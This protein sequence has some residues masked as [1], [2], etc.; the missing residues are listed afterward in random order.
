[1]K[2][3]FL[4]LAAALL[5]L[6]AGAEKII[7][8]AQDTVL[9]TEGS[10]SAIISKAF[11]VFKN[12]SRYRGK[13][14]VF[15]MNV[16]R[17]EGSSPLG[18]TF[19][20]STNPGNQLRVSQ[21][22]SVKYTKNGEKKALEF[23]LDIPD[24]NNIF[25]FNM[26]P[27]FR[28][29]GTE[30][31]VWEL[32]DIR[33]V[34]YE[35]KADAPKEK[36]QEAELEGF[37]AELA[38]SMVKTPLVLIK[39]GKVCFDIVTSD[40]PDAIAKYAAEEIRDHIKLACGSA[41]RIIRESQYKSGPAIMI[42]ETAIAKKYGI[43]PALL[44]PE[45]VV[46][47]RLGDVIVLSGGD[48]SDIPN[49]MVVSRAFVPVGTLYAAYEF[50]ER[51]AGCRW[52]WP[53][54]NGT[55]VPKCKDLSVNKLFITSRP[56]YDTRK[57]FYGT[58]RNDKDVTLLDCEKWYR[59]NRFGGS[60]GDPVAN[61]SFNSWIA[62]FAKSNPEYLALQADGSRKTNPEPGGGHVCMSH[63]GV[64]KQ[65]VAD[66]I[67]ELRKNKYSS[68]AKV[69]PGDSNGLFY[70]KCAE[71]QSKIVYSMGDRGLYSNV[72]WRF[73]NN[74]AAEVAKTLPGK[75]I[76]CCAYG[77]YL[78]KPQFPLMPNVA[79]TLCFSPVPRGSLT[80]KQ[81][82]KELLD[83]WSSTGAR[84]YVW[85]YW[86]ASRY[87]RGIYGTPAVFPRQLKEIYA[88]DAGRISGRAI[89]LSDIDSHGK[90]LNS[91]A[92]WLY[93]IQNLYAAG[94]LMWDP[95]ADIDRIM[96]EYCTDFFGPAAEPVRKFYEEM[97]LAWAKKGHL[98][99]KWNFQRV[100]KELYP[101]AFVDRMTGLLQEAVKL[102]GKEEPYAWRTRKLYEAYKPFDRNSRLFRGGTRKS[103]PVRIVVPRIAGKPADGDW[104][105]GALLK[106]FCDSYNVYQQDSETAMQLLH[107][108]KFLYVKA[109]CRI[110]MGVAGVT[111]AKPDTGKRDGL[112]WNY[113]SL[114][115]FLARGK[116]TYQFIL[117]PD[118]CLLDAFNTP[119]NPKGA[120]KWNSQKVQWSTVRKGIY[121]EGFL[122]IPLDEMK[123]SAKGKEGEFRFN[124]YRNCRYN[125]PGEPA[126]WEQS[127]YLPTFGGFHN[128]N[129]FGTLILG[130]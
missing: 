1:M 27:G 57:T 118:S 98:P 97:E 4:T 112:L 36:K 94:R 67:E 48:R 29:R 125:M 65:T 7:A 59:R 32:T 38:A 77:D 2:K 30:K 81:Q 62:R 50:L 89:E 73:V 14:V 6:P 20:C 105:K 37:A 63:P 41:P 101:P 9:S 31:C 10:K 111:W 33:F 64:F 116:E 85:E 70:C 92:D 56:V 34:E 82:W 87:A 102:A 19:R 43:N 17:L 117:A 127:C 60:L 22:H 104:K 84:L 108:G 91:W 99:G 74:V 123:F 23:I 35:E 115:F 53:G 72:V 58:I 18:V 107:D 15:R 13:K 106:D 42:G 55:H 78:R 71:C 51:I 24:L 79:V 103:N 121:W 3:V 95:A 46:V 45:N 110:P 40:K 61:H 21:N 90:G 54:K 44:A 86:N 39:E 122:A 11:Y 88:M 96:N 129:N 113:E 120:M 68:F 128:I 8:K 119:A 25:H 52:Y 75:K 80:Y 114:E 69:M 83:E 100:W 47:A 130:K 126:K 49:H 66:K 124:A 16:K 76:V 26:H 5:L 28:R 109:E 12:V 93:D